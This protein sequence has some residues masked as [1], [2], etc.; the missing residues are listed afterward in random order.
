MVL[1]IGTAADACPGEYPGSIEDIPHTERRLPSTGGGLREAYRA[2]LGSSDLRQS[3]Q[4][5]DDAADAGTSLARIYV[6]VVRP[7]L[8]PLCAGWEGA[9]PS[10][11]ERLLFSSVEAALAAVASR[12]A[13]GAAMHG[14]G[15]EALVSVGTGPLDALDGQ[16]IVDVLCA[17]GWTVKDV[18]AAARAEDVVSM[19]ADGHVQL[20]VM[21]TSN[22][23]DLLLSAKTYT[24]LRRLADPPVIVAC[25]LGNPGDT[26]RAR[27]AGADAFANDPDDLLRFAAARLPVAGARN[28]GVRLRRMGETLVVAPTGDLD[29]ASIR[30]LRQVVGSRA[31]TFDALVVDT[32]DVASVTHSGY[33]DL[34]TWMGEVPVD[35]AARRILPGGQ[36]TNA[37]RAP[38]DTALLATPADAGA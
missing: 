10:P 24:L 31:G 35:G 18:P 13:V 27:A 16:V 3:R 29:A 11:A 38:L 34:L 7:A 9:R 33:D 32:R 5:I 19:A 37:M 2:A 28:W 36:F 20:V 25:S 1:I 8:E 12:P 22:A 15:R 6:D 17:D 21:P 23:A 26:R 30:R 4:L 14:H